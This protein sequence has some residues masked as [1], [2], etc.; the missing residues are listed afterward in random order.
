MEV[1]RKT[2]QTQVP[3]NPSLVYCFTSESL[4][5]NILSYF[6]QPTVHA[7]EWT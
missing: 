4:R 3:V 7:S 1:Y 5:G 2:Y 6:F